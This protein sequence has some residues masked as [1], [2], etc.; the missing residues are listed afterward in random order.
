M[1]RLLSGRTAQTVSTARLLQGSEPIVQC[2]PT[3]GARPN[4]E[5]TRENSSGCMVTAENAEVSQ[6]VENAIVQGGV[7]GNRQS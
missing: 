1:C 4:K 3:S 2:A 7:S 6:T 5:T